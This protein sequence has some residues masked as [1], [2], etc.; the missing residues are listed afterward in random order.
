VT[1]LLEG[2]YVQGEMTGELPGMGAFRGLGVTGYDNVSRQF[3]SDWIDNHSTGIMSG[4]GELS[5]DGNTLTWRFT[6]NCPIT[7]KPSVVRQVETFTSADTMA[8]D[9]FSTNP[10]TGVESRCMHIEFTRAR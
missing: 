2:R 4:V 1:S 9:M 8:F 10:R 7:R 6:C 3:V 5:R